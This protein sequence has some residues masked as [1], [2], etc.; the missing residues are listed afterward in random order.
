MRGGNGKPGQEVE[1]ENLGTGQTVTTERV[2]E[3]R[4]LGDLLCVEGML[5]SYRHEFLGLMQSLLKEVKEGF[6]K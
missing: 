2:L 4:E 6:V 5:P 3:G 1:M